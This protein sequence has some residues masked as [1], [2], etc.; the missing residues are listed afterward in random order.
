MTY[1]VRFGRV[2]ENFTSLFEFIFYM[3]GFYVLLS[4]KKILKNE[5]KIKKLHLS[6]L[7][8]LWLSFHVVIF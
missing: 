1:F 4:V 6:V 3:V 2:L 7:F 5:I 8:N